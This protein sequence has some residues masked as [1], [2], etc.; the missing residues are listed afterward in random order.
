VSAGETSQPERNMP[1]AIVTTVVIVTVVYV[2]VQYVSIAGVPALAASTRP[3]ADL[4]M[5]ILGPS[6]SVVVAAG[7]IVMMVGTLLAVLLAAS[8]TLMAMSEQQQLPPAIA[9]LHPRLQTPAIAIVISA[10]AVLT[11]SLL[12]TFA[13]A[14]TIAVATRLFGYVLVCLAVPVLRRTSVEPPRFR[15]PFGTSIAIASAVL[16]ASLLT[17]ATVT[18]FATTL[19]LGVTGWAAWRVYERSRKRASNLPAST[20]AVS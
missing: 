20:S 17:T 3:L 10:A 16:S 4:A 7:A 8:R 12:S 5:Q 6:E 13:A 14:I 15:V 19:V 1:F 9:S 11:V 18:E 2:L